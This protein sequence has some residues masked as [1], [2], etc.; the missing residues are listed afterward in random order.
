MLDEHETRFLESS[1]GNPD[2]INAL[3]HRLREKMQGCT[4][5]V[6]KMTGDPERLMEEGGEMAKVAVSLLR[7]MSPAAANPNITSGAALLGSELIPAHH[8][9]VIGESSFNY[10]E[11]LD[12]HAVPLL[13][14]SERALQALKSNLGALG[15]LVRPEGLTPFAFDLRSSLLLFSTGLTLWIASHIVFRRSKKSCSGIQ[16]KHGSS[17]SP[18][19]CSS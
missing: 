16:Q 15:S 11:G 7:F 17:I 18:R 4:A 2:D 5:V 12:I 6:I 8:W 10:S 19:G 3:F 1:Q 14:M 9:L 13:R